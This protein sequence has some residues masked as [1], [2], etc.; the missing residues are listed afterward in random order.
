MTMNARI[1]RA[2]TVFLGSMATP[3]TERRAALAFAGGQAWE[4]RV[5]ALARDAVFGGVER[6]RARRDLNLLT[7]HELADIGMTRGDIDRVLAEG[8]TR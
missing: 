4:A 1:D 6:S 2:E 3:K 7:D 5:F 8:E